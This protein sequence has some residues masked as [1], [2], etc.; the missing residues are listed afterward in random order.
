[1]GDSLELWRNITSSTRHAVRFATETEASGF[2]GIGVTDSQNLA[3]DCW[4]AL[5][6]MAGV[7]KT[8]KLATG[9]T[10]PVTRHPA[11]TASAAHALNIWSP[12]PDG[13][14]RV[15]IGIGRG[16]SALAHLGRA[17]AS[18]KMLESYLRALSGYLTGNGVAFDELNFHES[19]APDV[20]DLGMADT[21]ERSR[22][23][24]RRD[25]DPTVG[26]EVTA[27][28]PK[29]IA[30]AARSSDRV[31]LVLGADLDRLQWG[32]DVARQARR[33]AN[34][35]PDDLRVGAYIQ[36]VPHPDI[37]AARKMAEGSLTTLARFSVMHGKVNGPVSD[38]QREVLEKIH[39]SYNMKQHTRTGS[40][41]AGVLTPAFI[42]SYSAV[43]PAD[44]CVE[45]LQRIADL[46]IDKVVVSGPSTGSDRETAAESA[47]LMTERVIPELK[48]ALS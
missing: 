48:A 25:S 6:A 29:V 36:V 26:V 39:S 35:D 27:S 14:G 9:V 38:T 23:V 22:L 40:D 11:V 32:I 24:W 16:D 4:V 44:L 13:S 45:K 31:L 19:V 17:P 7:T 20:S 43:G 28:G 1:M 34:L 15:T 21:V 12:A 5:T 8:L 2:D 3:G 33:D 30:A 46:G 18:V 10:N 37:E 42:D 41:Q 47:G